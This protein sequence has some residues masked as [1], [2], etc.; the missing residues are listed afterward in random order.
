MRLAT[1]PEEAKP[2]LAAFARA[3]PEAHAFF[4]KVQEELAPPWLDARRDALEEL[5]PP[6]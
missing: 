5:C 2:E 1:D 4:W 3:T 6:S